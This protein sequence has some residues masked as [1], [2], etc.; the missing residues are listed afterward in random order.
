MKNK[1]LFICS[2]AL[3]F[4]CVGM[5]AVWPVN[6]AM[7]SN[8][9]TTLIPAV[10][11]DLSIRKTVDRDPVA[12]GSVVLWTVV[13][14]NPGPDI[15]QNVVVTD[16]LPSNI[17]SASGTISSG[18]NCAG[19]TVLT[20]PVGPLTP[21]LQVTVTIFAFVRV[22]T[23]VGT[24]L[25]NTA[26]VTSSTADPNP[27]NNSASVTTTVVIL[28]DIDLRK[29]DTP[30]VVTRTGTLQ[31]GDPTFNRVLDGSDAAH[32]CFLS[33]TGTAVP[34]DL[35]TFALSRTVK[36]DLQG[37][38]LVDPFLLLYS[39]V[40]DPANPCANLVAADDDSGGGLA[41]Q[42]FTTLAPGN[43]VIVAT[44]FAN[45]QQGTYTLTLSYDTFNPVIAAGQNLIY[46]LSVRNRGPTPAT[47]IAVADRLPAQ[48]T[49]QSLLLSTPLWSC[50]TPGVGQTGVVNCSANTITRTET[51]TLVVNVKP[52]TPGGTMLENRA[53]ACSSNPD[54]NLV[55]N[56]VSVFT[57]VGPLAASATATR[58]D[59]PIVNYPS[60]PAETQPCPPLF[61][62][63]FLP[64]M[65]R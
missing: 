41:P 29:I 54:P 44:T 52:G 56:S 50:S 39:G 49:F 17:S 2:L 4:T 43:Y 11:A 57:T 10:S 40:F 59:T 30:A 58:T 24:V 6:A 20:C 37:G 15:A 65:Q 13:I 31:T 9:A 28:S 26:T 53:A 60:T 7:P 8:N 14:S 38:T 21:T 34:Y 3:L 16:T 22:T 5:L 61:P 45:G 62:W 42:I 64:L 51:F 48:T 47:N 63:L 33:G 46:V 35:Y 36:I 32:G 27:A 19:R 1:Y 12:A 23:T 55:N 25:T 18:G